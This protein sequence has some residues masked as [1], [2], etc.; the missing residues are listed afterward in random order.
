VSE[1]RG[2]SGNVGVVF[3]PLIGGFIAVVIITILLGR[4]M[5][6]SDREH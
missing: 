1:G 5:D 2:R 3:W 4:I 6:P